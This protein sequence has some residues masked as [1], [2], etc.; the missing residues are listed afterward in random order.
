M[1]DIKANVKEYV[2]SA[3]RGMDVLKR[4]DMNPFEKKNRSECRRLLDE[5]VTTVDG[6]IDVKSQA[7][8]DQYNTIMEKL[9]TWR[10]RIA[11]NNG[12]YDTN[13]V[14][15]LQDSLKAAKTWAGMPIPTRS[16]SFFSKTPEVYNLPEDDLTRVMHGAQIGQDVNLFIECC[17]R[18]AKEVASSDTGK[19]L[20]QLREEQVKLRDIEREEQDV[21]SLYKNGEVSREEAEY[22]LEEIGDRKDAIEFEIQRLVGRKGDGN[23]VEIANR[24]QLLLKIEKP[25]RQI[26]ARV[27]GNYLHIHTIFGEVDFSTL[28]GVLNGNVGSAEFEASVS[29]LQNVLFSSGLINRQGEVNIKEIDQRLAYVDQV[30][31]PSKKK[32]QVE[33]QKPKSRLDDAIARMDNKDGGDRSRLDTLTEQSA[34]SSSKTSKLDDIL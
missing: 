23:R 34:Q 28:I 16:P 1:I 18:L 25:I 12:V 20:E 33:V 13:S 26:Y 9:N 27:K 31:N 15:L 5:I 19:I 3:T 2:E 11:R 4:L 8:A 17:D 22:T 7:A 21:V 30:I 32:D 14:S 10:S 24:R 6:V 29:A